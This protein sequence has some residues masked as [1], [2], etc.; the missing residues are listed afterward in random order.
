MKKI[1]AVALTLVLGLGT[2]DLSAQGLLR[3]LGRAVEKAVNDTRKKPVQQQK[4]QTVQAESKPAEKVATPPPADAT[5]FLEPIGYRTFKGAVDAPFTLPKSTG[6]SAQTEWHKSQEPVMTLSNRRLVEEYAALEEWKKEASTV[7]E[8][9]AVYILNLGDEISNRA[10]A[11]NEFVRLLEATRKK[12]PSGDPQWVKNR[13]MDDL[14]KHLN[15]DAYKRAVNSSIAP[16]K[17]LLNEAALTYFES[18]GGLENAAPGERTVW[19]PYETEYVT[20]SITGLEGCMADDNNAVVEDITY[21]LYPKTSREPARASIVKANIEVMEGRDV[22]IPDHIIRDGISYPVTRIDNAPFYS[23]PIKSIKLPSTLKIIGQNAFAN[24]SLRTVTIPEGVTEL[25]TACFHDSY[26]LKE[27]IIPNSVVKIGSG[28]FTNCKALKSAT[29][30]SA[31]RNE[32]LYDIFHETPLLPRD[33]SVDF[34]KFNF[35]D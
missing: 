35:V 31:Y 16:L 15:S 9:M 22:V 10:K 28:C 17:H 34:S 18:K 14:A 26:Q 3:N 23:A 5:A 29:L 24:T 12:I 25:G 30:P 7:R 1:A 21:R 33:T 2:A 11:I 8:A 6:E 27:I 13:P 20:T 32:G 4:T 19:Q